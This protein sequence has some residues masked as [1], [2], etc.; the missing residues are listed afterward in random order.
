MALFGKPDHKKDE[1]LI[2][3]EKARMQGK[4]DWSE[5]YWKPLAHE[6]NA[7]RIM[8]PRADSGASYHLKIS[9][10]FI[11]HPDK[12]E[13][14]TCMKETY[15]KPCPACEEW[16]RLLQEA[17][18]IKDKD[19]KQKMKDEA[20][21]F[22]PQRF[23]VFN[24]VGVEYEKD[25]TRVVPEDAK[26]KLY[27]SPMTVWQKI[28]AV[29]STRSRMSD[30]FDEFKN[31][32]GEIEKPG[33][34]IMVTYDPDQTPQHRYNAYPTDRVEMGTPEE[35]LKW[36]GE[37]TDLIPEN[38]AFAV[39]YDVAHMKTFGS[40]EERNELR[41]TLKEIWKAQRE[42]AQ[43]AEEEEEEKEEAPKEK[44][45]E[46]VKKTKGKIESEAEAVVEEK[47]KEK[48]K[49]EEK[50]KEEEKPKPEKEQEEEP[51]KG[52]SA[53]DRLKGKLSEIKDK[54]D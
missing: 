24:V 17:N 14:F 31:E 28:I 36:Y 16:Q 18:K 22:K 8:P 51:V 47:P 1:E 53:L 41:E 15:G 40:K 19:E 44:P 9:K 7:I 38:V 49:A 26:V 32:K 50:P 33:R 2:E 13:T 30:I 45:K 35:V 46:E 23:G 37:I 43:Q 11:R 21:R 4:V 6:E 3:K 20:R 27:E 52:S 12:T 39:E 29:V 54:Q 5:R 25:G 10:H 42:E 34:D 48:K